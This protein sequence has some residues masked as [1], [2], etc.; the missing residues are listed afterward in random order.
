MMQKNYLLEA[1]ES[2]SKAHEQ[3]KNTAA[4]SEYQGRDI[5]VLEQK[6]MDFRNSSIQL[7][8]ANG[9]STKIVAE[10]YGMSS[11]RISQ[12]APRKNKGKCP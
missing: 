2:I 11:A 4:I 12:I 10:K 7:E 9:A 5:A 6:I 1:L 8:V 3:L